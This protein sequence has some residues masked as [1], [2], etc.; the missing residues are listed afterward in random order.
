[1]ITKTT[2][3]ESILG[4]TLNKIELKNKD[5]L[6]FYNSDNRHW[7]MYHNQ[8][9]CESV[10]IEDICGCLDDLTETPILI[11][12]EIINDNKTP[13]DIN[14]SSYPLLYNNDS[15]TWTFYKLATIKGYVTIRW[16]GES[17][18]YYAESVDFIEVIKE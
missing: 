7:I 13:E 10:T 14:Q 6:H 4:I 2:N 15:Y 5:E 17:N 3:I 8:Y 1:M 18:G 16:Y 12:E 9:C 11:A